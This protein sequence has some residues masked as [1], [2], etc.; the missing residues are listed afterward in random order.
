MY[1][2]RK[3]K[4]TVRQSRLIKTNYIRSATMLF[5]IHIPYINVAQRFDQDGVKF[6]ATAA[7]QQRIYD[8]SRVQVLRLLRL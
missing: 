8:M 5:I 2:V 3:E 6:R 4:G 1:K 7:M